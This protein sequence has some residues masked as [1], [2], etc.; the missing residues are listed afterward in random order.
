MKTSTDEQVIN[1]LTEIRDGVNANLVANKQTA[2]S[3]T[4]IRADIGAIREGRT[5][6]DSRQHEDPLTRAQRRQVNEV[7]KRYAEKLITNPHYSLLSISKAVRREDL[8]K[9]V[10]GGYK[11]DIALNSRASKEFHREQKGLPP[12]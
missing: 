11:T 10:E 7:K 2:R 12:F 1:L 5:G 6:A 3:S 4:Y 8:S 9:G